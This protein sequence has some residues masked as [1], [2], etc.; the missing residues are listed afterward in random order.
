MRKIALLVIFL[1]IYLVAYNQVIKG[2]V[3]DKE[4][5]R[6]VSS[7]Y[8]YYDGTFLWT[9]TDESGH[10]EFDIAKYTTMPISISAQGYN[11]VNLSVVSPDKQVL[12]YIS[13][14]VTEFEKAGIKSKDFD[15]E[16]IKR[17]RSFKN[18]F[19]GTTRN[20]RNCEITNENDIV[21]IS[22]SDTLK[23]FSLKPII[24]V[25]K[26]LGYRLT[27][28]LDKLE[29][30]KKDNTFTFSGSIFFNEDLIEE[31]NKEFYEI[32]RREA[33]NESVICFF[34]S[35]WKNALDSDGFV[36]KNM[37]DRLLAYDEIVI[38]K[39]SLSKYLICHSDLPEKS[40]AEAP[41]GYIIFRE[42]EVYYDKDGKLHPSCI[43][44][45]SLINDIYFDKNGYFDSS[46]IKWE[47]KMA[48]QRVADWLPYEYSINN[49]KH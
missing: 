16:R 14:K 45:A 49:D 21:F 32:K 28:F 19:L 42:Q 36:V 9:K 33:Y 22:C 3:L 47:G 11:S 40:R 5:H 7:A 30:Y 48:K 25:N 18:T 44:I 2:V 27:Y 31:N 37:E 15:K 39:E 8:V 12:I 29:L 26:A 41:Q 43:S 6:P 35:L 38:Q 34:R 20:A 46:G 23:A 4:S 10:F 13:P 24:V 1:N 17:L